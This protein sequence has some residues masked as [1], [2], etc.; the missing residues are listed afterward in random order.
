MISNLAVCLGK[1]QL[2]R[3]IFCKGYERNSMEKKKKKLCMR[4]VDLE[5]AFD[6]VRRKVAE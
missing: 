3:C 2:V 1:A 6:R 4:F 5:K